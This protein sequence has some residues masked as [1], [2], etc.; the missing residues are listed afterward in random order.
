MERKIE[1]LRDLLLMQDI[2][3]I[4]YTYSTVEV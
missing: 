4:L 1:S 3:S 2:G